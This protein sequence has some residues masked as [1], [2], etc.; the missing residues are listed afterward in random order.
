MFSV[1]PV[2]A[3]ADAA[4]AAELSA[5]LESAFPISGD[6]V[7]CDL[8]DARIQA[9]EDLLS[10]AEL[11][12]SPDVLLLLLSRA[13]N[14]PHWS[15]DRWQP[16]LGGNPAETGTWVAVLWLEDC[17]FP[18]LLKRGSGFFDARLESCPGGSRLAV[19]RRIKRWLRGIRMGTAPASHFSADLEE[20]YR[21]SA[22]RPGRI[23]ASGAL[24]ERFAREALYDFEAVYWVPA[25]GRNL[26]QVAGELGSQ[27]GLALDGMPEQNCAQIRQVLSARRCLLVL[28]APGIDLSPILPVGFTSTI[29]T[30]EPVRI[31]KEDFTLAAARALVLARRF[32][33]AYELLYRLLDAGMETEACARE[34]VWICEHWDRTEEANQLR[35]H[36]GAPVCEQLRLF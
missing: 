3:P 4:V 15:R 8:A 1:L 21:A 12:Q 28:D 35:F 36:P 10:A 14:L 33:E 26:T 19:F 7:R 6:G 23:S 31:V 2:H 13:S 24:A 20:L 32:A 11:G 29:I 16:L 18:A 5:F 34:L 9:G 27:M 25:H 17:E 22:D 30:T